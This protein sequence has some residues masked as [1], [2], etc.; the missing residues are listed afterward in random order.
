MAE[1]NSIEHSWT[2]DSK[3]IAYMHRRSSGDL[4]VN[5]SCGAIWTFGAERSMKHMDSIYESHLKY[6]NR[7]KMETL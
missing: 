1:S 2:W 3:H 6:F 4:E 7:P 5:C